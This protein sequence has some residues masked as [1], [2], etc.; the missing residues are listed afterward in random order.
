MCPRGQGIVGTTPWNAMVFFTL[1]LQLLGFSDF[2]SSTLMAVFA[3]GCAMGAFAG[4]SVGERRSKPCTP[5]PCPLLCAPA[6]TLARWT[7]CACVAHVRPGGPH[8][9][10]RAWLKVFIPGIAAW[11]T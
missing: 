6:L 1:W 7:L 2:V 3:C 8:L 11:C 10:L 9:N 4:G 5:L